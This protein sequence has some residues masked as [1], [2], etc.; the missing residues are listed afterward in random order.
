MATRLKGVLPFTS[1]SFFLYSF[2]TQI[3]RSPNLR[4]VLSCASLQILPLLLNAISFPIFHMTTTSM[5]VGKND[6]LEVDRLQ[7]Q[8][9][10]VDV[11]SHGGNKSLVKIGTNLGALA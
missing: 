7:Q 11:I 9:N 3:F 1:L 2:I 4:P 5:R 10:A 8:A 6:Q